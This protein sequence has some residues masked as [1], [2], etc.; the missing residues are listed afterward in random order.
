MG[1]MILA[2]LIISGIVIGSVSALAGAGITLINRISGLINFAHAD[3]IM[4][5]QYISYWLLVLYGI[6]PLI[7]VPIAAFFNAVFGVFFY[8]YVI[9]RMINHPLEMQMFATF[10][11][12]SLVQYVALMLWSP[13]PRYVAGLYPIYLSG[14]I[15]YGGIVIE[16]GELAT[17]IAS[18]TILTVLHLYIKYSRTGKGIRATSQDRQAALSLGVD[19]HKMYMIS[20]GLALALSGIA[21][22][23]I[24]TF[25]PTYPLV[26]QAFL[27]SSITAS[28]IGGG[29][30]G[31]YF[32]GLITGIGTFAL[33]VFLPGELG[34]ASF[35]QVYVWMFFFAVIIAIQRR[36][37][38]S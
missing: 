8:N 23:F 6:D 19:V 26:G 2:Q 18:I 15:K 20:W 13:Q 32:G 31:S 36:E 37:G 5:G 38:S 10:G 16:V 33:G 24:S 34:G 14:I 35:R 12:S 9:K 29:I 28:L 7:S 21:G 1:D 11:L 30:I 17:C 25:Y 4:I 27:I 22:A 3:F